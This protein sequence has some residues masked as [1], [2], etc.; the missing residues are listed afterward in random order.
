M[1]RLPIKPSQTPA[2]TATLPRRFA[3]AAPAPDRHSS[4]QSLGPSPGAPLSAVASGY[5]RA[6]FSRDLTIDWAASHYPLYPGGPL[7]NGGPAPKAAL[8]TLQSKCP[9]RQILWSRRS[10]IPD[11]SDT[12]RSRRLRRARRLQDKLYSGSFW[13]TFCYCRE[14]GSSALTRFFCCQ[15]KTVKSRDIHSETVGRHLENATSGQMF[16]V[17]YACYRGRNL[18]LLTR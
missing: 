15:S 3:S 1:I 2:T 16:F 9:V 4:L 11:N 17:Q 13:S 7:R 6:G 5:R 10:G 8:F 12:R 18:Y 14:E